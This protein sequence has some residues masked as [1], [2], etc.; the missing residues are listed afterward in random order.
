MA[1]TLTEKTVPSLAP[2][3]SGPYEIRDKGGKQSVKGL[4]VRVQ[5]SGA[6]TYYVELSRGK[7]ERI[8]DASQVTLTYARAEAQRLIGLF[9]QG[10]DFQ[11]ERQHKRALKQTTLAG[12]MDGDFK[13]HAEA[14]IANSKYFLSSIKNNFAHVLDKPMTEITELDLAKWNRNRSNVTISTRRRELANLK[15]L[16]NHAVATK[17][18]PEHQLGS[19]RLKAAITDKQSETKV[20]YLTDDEETR[21]RSALDRREQEM[22]EARQRYRKWQ[23][24]RGQ[25]PL[26][27]IKK[28][29]YADHLKPLV[30]LALLTGLRRGDLFSLK[31]EHVDLPRAQIRKVIGKTSHSARKAGRDPAPAVL[32]LSKEAQAVLRQCHKQRGSSPYVFVSP[33][34]GGALT[35]VK[36]AFN[37]VIK[38]ANIQDFRFHDLR[39]TFASRLVMAGVDLNT[40]RELMT[41]ADIKM[42]LIYAHLSPD[43]KAAALERAFGGVK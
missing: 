11:A 4:L 22:R 19:Y 20:R 13:A 1:A 31:W 16:L 37:S 34:S 24:E 29:E 14:N 38:A 10:H 2:R 12:Y 25:E 6:K 40:V 21:L 35:D 18:I 17:V 15:S 26:P 41:H 5:K 42:T 23:L 39:H 30:L 28:T 36:G 7:R 27:P 32:P 43:H 33:L 9:L 8:G 3:P